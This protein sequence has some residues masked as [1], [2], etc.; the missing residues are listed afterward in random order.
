[1]ILRRLA[2]AITAQN[3]FTVVL[4]VLIVVV[5]IFIGLQVDEW[6]KGRIEQ[7]EISEFAHALIKDLEQD[8]VMAEPIIVQMTFLQEKIDDLATYMQ[9]KS[10]D[11][12]KNIDLYYFMRIP[13]YRPY[14]WNR[15]TLEQMKSSGAIRQMENR[16]LA[17]K[18]S[19]Y[20]AFTRHLDEDFAY[21][22]RIGVSSSSLASRV[23]DMNY[24][25]I[26]EVASIDEQDYFKS[27]SQFRR[28]YEGSDLP[29]LKNDIHEI[30][31]AVNSFLELGGYMGIRARVEIEMPRLKTDARKLIELLNAE[32]PD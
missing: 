13:Y 16:S 7:K 11:Q 28:V 32:Y 22:R 27:L 9:G 12:L 25:N 20:D 8:L 26:N 30:K 6:N 18:I 3:W 15:T 14:A 17:E 1:M 2:N 23:V 19:A 24:P 31:V 10:V 5:G 4:E 29:L 21:D